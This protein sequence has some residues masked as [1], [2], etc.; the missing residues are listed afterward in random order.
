MNLIIKH[1]YFIE[2]FTIYLQV[3]RYQD[4]QKLKDEKEVLEIKK[5]ETAQQVAQII[6]VHCS[7]SLFNL[8]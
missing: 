5:F 2:F 8:V 3:T 4:L 1:I 7:V 6:E